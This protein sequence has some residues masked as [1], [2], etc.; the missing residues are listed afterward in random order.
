MRENAPQSVPSALGAAS[1]RPFRSVNSLLRGWVLPLLA[2]VLSL[3]A[4]RSAVADWNDVP[5]GSMKPTILE[6]DRVFVDRRAYDLKVPFTRARLAEWGAPGRGEIVVFA[7]PETG[8]R[9]VKRVVGLPGDHVA[10]VGDRLV[11]N[12]R[13]ASYE[14]LDRSRV[15]GLRNDELSGARLFTE[16]LDGRSHPVLF[17]PRMAAWR[18]F[19]PVV[20]ASDRYFMLGDNRDESHDSRWF[21]AVSRDRILGRA[22]AVVASVDRERSFR[23]RLERF[24]SPLR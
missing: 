21:G 3:T 12:G 15:P 10:L 9:L 5:T 18:S 4:F 22:V 8:E 7:S 17:W 14:A 19:G 13:E 6:G 24:F 23:P 16:T 11:V 1:E 2:M 20:V